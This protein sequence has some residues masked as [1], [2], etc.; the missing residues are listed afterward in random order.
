MTNEED[1]EL[2]AISATMKALGDLDIAQQKS[3]LEYVMS[4]L[5]ITTPKNDGGRVANTEDRNP[6][7]REKSPA[8]T[9]HDGEVK[10][11]RTLK[12]EK[13]P[14]SAIQMAVLVAYY[15]SRVVPNE[16][17]MDFIGTN[18]IDKY[19]D[20]AKYPLP[21]ST[22]VL[23]GDAKRAGYLES[24][25]RGKYKLNPVGY[26]LA[27]HSMGSDNKGALRTPYSPKK[28]RAPKKK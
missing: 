2:Q 16:E 28:N 26:N 25:E 14:K 24:T 4:R 18:E 1:K 3:A 21:K 22:A 12:E 13:N 7:V 10:D 6:E 8:P 27:A 23:L 9:R 19:F 11:I 15:L 20:Q 5:G 17:K